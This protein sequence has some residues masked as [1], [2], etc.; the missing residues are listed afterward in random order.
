MYI[1]TNIRIC[2]LVYIEWMFMNYIL[3]FYIANIVITS[4]I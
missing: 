2:I 1:N 3:Y 4:I